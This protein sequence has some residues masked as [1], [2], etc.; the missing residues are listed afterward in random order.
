VELSAAEHPAE[1]IEGTTPAIMVPTLLL[2]DETGTGK[3]L[4]TVGGE[5]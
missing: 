2:Q 3:G 1:R 5:S 4:T